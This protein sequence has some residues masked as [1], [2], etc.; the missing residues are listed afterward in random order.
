[1]R[2]Q[3]WIK[4][5]KRQDILTGLSLFKAGK[6]YILPKQILFILQY[7]LLTPEIAKDV[8]FFIFF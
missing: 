2:A 5:N 3:I 8:K 4:I 1:M 7:I 6:S